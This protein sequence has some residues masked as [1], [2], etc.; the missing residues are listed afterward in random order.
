MDYSILDY[1]QLL[2]EQTDPPCLSLYQPT[3]RQHPDN[4]QDPIRFGNLVKELEESLRQKYPDRAIKPLLAPFLKLADDRRFWNHTQDAIAVLASADTFKVYRLQRPVAELALVADSFHTKPLMRI[5]QS[6]DRYQILGLNRH[7][8][9]LYEG[10]RDMLDQIELPPAVPATLDSALGNRQAGNERSEGTSYDGSMPGATVRRTKDVHQEAVQRDTERF[11]RIVDR[12]I[13][14][15]FS[16]PNGVPL[17]LAALPEHHNLF[18]R[19]SQSPYLAT[20]ALAVHPEAIAI[21]DL[22]ERTWEIMLPRYLER[23]TGLV[24]AYADAGTKGL[25]T[26][27]LDEAARAALDGRIATLLIEADRLI[28]GRIDADSGKVEHGDLN[29]PDLDDV[30]DDLGEAVIRGGGEV[31]IVPSDRMPTQTGIAATYRF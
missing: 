4:Q 20:D 6:A 15:N 12:A 23:L 8:V 27:D 14:E 31:I 26:S 30:L 21:S 19:I 9:C 7:S 10:N 25:G 28:P 3:H 2:R 1:S 11:F 13:L 22:Q 18:R 24:N 5:S 29:N 17:I 16:R